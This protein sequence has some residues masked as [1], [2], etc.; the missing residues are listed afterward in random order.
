MTDFLGSGPVYVRLLQ[1]DQYGR[2]VA[3]VFK[4]KFFFGKQFVDEEMLTAGMAEVYQG[5]GA[6]YGPKVSEKR[7]QKKDH[8]M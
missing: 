6:V 8:V 4:R 7:T 2:A 1:R 5:G 3:Q